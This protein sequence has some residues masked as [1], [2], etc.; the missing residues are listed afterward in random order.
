M[1]N[2]SS[3]S[4]NVVNPQPSSSGAGT[5]T[6]HLNGRVDATTCPNPTCRRVQPSQHTSGDGGHISRY[7]CTNPKCK[8]VWTT[9]VTMAR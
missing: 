4:T 8:R 2:T 3:L 7:T 6:Q 9:G 1:P 5:P